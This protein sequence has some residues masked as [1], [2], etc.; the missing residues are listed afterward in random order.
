MARRIDPRAEPASDPP[1][2]KKSIEAPP[3]V[4]AAATAPIVEVAPV[5]VVPSVDPRVAIVETAL[6]SGDWKQIVTE[7][8]PLKD[9]ALLPPT[10]ALINAVAHIE[11]SSVQAAAPEAH[12]QAIHSM[13]TIF[14]VSPESRLAIVFAKR[15]TRRHVV[16]FRERPAPPPRISFLIIAVTLVLALALGWLLTSGIVRVQLH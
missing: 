7:L 5:P 16:S 1:P 8:G 9:A 12:A 14:G 15:L 13:A 3:V 4:A 2:E 10:L 11:A 6:A